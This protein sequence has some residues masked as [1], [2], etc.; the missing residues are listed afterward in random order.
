MRRQLLPTFVNPFEAVPRFTVTHSLIVVLSPM[1]AVVSS[2]L[3]LRSCGIP[4]TVAWGK[5]TQFLPTRAPASTVAWAITRV[6]SPI[7]VFSST[8]AK[9]STITFSP[10]MASGCTNA[11]EETVVI[12]SRC[13]LSIF[14]N[15]SGKIGF[16]NH[17]ISYKRQASHRGDSPPHFTRQLH[18]EEDR[19]PRNHLM[20]EFHIVNLQEIGR[21]ALRFVQS[22]EHKQAAG[23]RHRF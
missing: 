2:P 10:R 18:P 21:I 12:Y 4:E 3:N 19:I 22:R 13:N 23:L 15:L 16:R 5:I 14:N 6:P 7:S 20:P 17:L 1:I 8:Y 9:G 11:K